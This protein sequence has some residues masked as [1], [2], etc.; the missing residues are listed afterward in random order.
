[1]RKIIFLFFIIAFIVSCGEHKKN[2]LTSPVAVDSTDHKIDSFFPVT[3]FLKG[4]MILLDSLPVTPLHTITVNNKTDSSWLK[5]DELRPLLQIFLT[6]EIAETNLTTLFKESSFNDQTLN[7]MT[8]TYEPVKLLPDSISLRHW[9]VYIDP[10]KGDVTKIYLVKEDKKDHLYYQL[11]WKPKY[12]AKITTIQNK[13]DGNDV[14]TRE[15]KII[16]GFTEE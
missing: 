7:A 13:P 14:V 15:E 1:M 5:K 11:L 10:L 8:F 9:T 2:N 16:W 3:S 4:Q 12:W 6:P